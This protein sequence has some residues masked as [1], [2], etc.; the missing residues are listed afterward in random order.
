MHN[1]L[2]LMREKVEAVVEELKALD[3]DA[4]EIVD[5]AAVTRARKSIANKEAFRMDSPGRGTKGSD[6][7]VCGGG[8][9][10]R[11]RTICSTCKRPML[12]LK[13]WEKLCEDLWDKKKRKWDISKVPEIHDAVKYDLIHHKQLVSGFADLCA[14]SKRLNDVIVPREYGPDQLN[15]ARIG[16][17]VCQ[18]LVR[19]LLI[20]MTN[21]LV[22]PAT[23]ELPPGNLVT[24]EEFLA[25]KVSHQDEP[26]EA[27]PDAGQVPEM[28]ELADEAEFAG[29]DA[30]RSAAA[31]KSPHRRVRTRLYF[32]SES[33]I[34]T[35]MNALRYCHLAHPCAEPGHPDANV[36]VVC[37]EA[38]ECLARAPVFEYLSQVVL[39]LY[40]D[41]NCASDSPERHRVE[42]LFSPGADGDPEGANQDHAMALAPLRPLHEPGQP[43][44][45]M[46]VQELLG[47]FSEELLAS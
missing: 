21:C 31:L 6:A 37:P 17:M 32:T 29:L 28:P 38:E 1:D 19:K 3:M 46:Q 18:R 2:V 42:V 25:R 14:V 12:C 13:R 8:C 24:A 16:G 4:I 45:L 10:V 36:R 44:T 39:R 20:D 26:K 40:E 33:H 43:L 23:E 34:Q 47:P 7:A 27:A 35:L 41:K 30:S 22:T 15:R 9:S 11:R 5:C